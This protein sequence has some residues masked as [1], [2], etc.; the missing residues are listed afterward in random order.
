MDSG[1]GLKAGRTAVGRAGSF[2]PSSTEFPVPVP[3]NEEMAKRKE[4]EGAEE[5]AEM[6][7]VL[8]TLSASANPN[9]NDP[10]MSMV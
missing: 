3:E 8:E 5:H 1:N 6:L 7:S 10:V 4:L 9:T 2:N